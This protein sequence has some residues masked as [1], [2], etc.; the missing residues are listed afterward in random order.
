[1][2]AYERVRALLD[3]VLGY[4]AGRWVVLRLR[5]FVAL[6]SPASVL[7]WCIGLFIGLMGS[8]VLL[9]L[10]RAG[11]GVVITDLRETDGL[12]VQGGRLNIIVGTTKTRDCPTTTSRYLWRWVADPARPEQRIK[13]HV[14]LIGPPV[15]LS[16]VGVDQRSILSLP[17]PSDIQDG[18]GWHYQSKSMRDCG[19]L[20]ALASTTVSQ[21][22]S[23]P[24]RV[25]T[26]EEAKTLTVQEG[27]VAR[28]D[29]RP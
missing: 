7:V 29:L 28:P 16:P 6:F 20:P 8:V 15:P 27:T 17:L 22:A 1:M 11:S 12:I 25:L 24:L 3:G 14:P 10:D 26:S 5:N 9:A 13:L 4:P 21:S 19:L 2:R 18:E 23:I